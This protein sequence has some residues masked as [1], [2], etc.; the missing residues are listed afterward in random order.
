MIYVY[1]NHKY[2]SWEIEKA[3]RRDINFMWMLEGTKPPDHSTIAKFCSLHFA[4]V[5]I[6]MLFVG[7][8]KK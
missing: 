7:N 1:M 2:S 3:C 8:I 6:S 5:Q 4:P